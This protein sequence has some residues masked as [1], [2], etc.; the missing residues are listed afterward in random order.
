MTL[1]ELVPYLKALRDRAATAAPPT[2]MAMADTYQNHLTRVTLRRSFVAPGTFG[3]PA[4]PGSPPA[5]RT[6][7]LA[8]S[9]R[10]A[11]PGRAGSPRVPRW[12]PIRST[13]RLRSMV[14]FTE[15]AGAKYMH[16]VNSGGEWY[17]KRVDIPPGPTWSLRC[18]KSSRTGRCQGSDGSVHGGRVGVNPVPDLPDVEE[19]FES[20][21]G[22]YVAGL[23]LMIAA[24]EKAALANYE[25]IASMGAVQA[26]SD[27][28]RGVPPWTRQRWRTSRSR[29]GTQRGQKPKLPLPSTRPGTRRRERQETRLPWQRRRRLRLTLLCCG[30][31]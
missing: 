8:R 14:A 29:P 30:E 10:T 3:T 2:V 18:G 26:A 15:R 17:K 28:L 1:E 19:T 11:G 4:A 31:E 22:L 13:P 5:W 25:L 23:D 21:N 24:A 27:A 7:R 6:G 20:R 12:L 16:W 9:V